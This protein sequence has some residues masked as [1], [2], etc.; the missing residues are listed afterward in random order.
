[1]II[2]LGQ[3]LAYLDPH[4]QERQ[5]MGQA[6]VDETSECPLI[7]FFV[8]YYLTQGI[9]IPRLPLAVYDRMNMQ[10]SREFIRCANPTCEI[11]NRLELS[12]DVKFK[13]CSRCLAVIYCSRECQVAHYPKHKACCKKGS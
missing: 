4:K 11:N 8:K 12:A 9:E 1:M 10:L 5:A 6:A 2:L 13:K 3:V 7:Y